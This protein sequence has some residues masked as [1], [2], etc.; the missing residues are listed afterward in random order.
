MKTLKLLLTLV[1]LSDLMTAP[2]RSQQPA[3]IKIDLDHKIAKIDPNI[4]GAFVEPI[5]TVVYGSIYDPKSPFADENGFRKDFVQLAKELNIPVVRW[6]GGNYVSGY[7]WEDGIGPKDQRPTRLDLAWH[8]VESNQ[9]GTDEYA[10][11]CSLI[12]A[13]NF[14]CINAG[15][16]TLDQARH[17]VEYCNY[18]GGTYYSDLRRKY[19]NEKPFKVKYWALGNEIDGPWQMG[20]K[21]AEDYCKF[22]LEAAKIM[23]WVDKD[24]KLIACGA[25]NYGRGTNNAWIDWNDYVLEHMIGKIDYLS[26]HRYVREALGSDTNFPGMMSLGLDIDQKIEIVKALIKKA[27]AK[28]GSLRPVYISFDEWSGGGPGTGNTLTASLMVAQHLNAFIRHADIVK[29][30]NIT[31]LSSLVGNAPEG[32]FKNAL[33]KAFYLYSNNSRGTALDVYADCEKYSNKIFTDIPYLDVTAVLS[34]SGKTMVLNV[35]NRHEK[36]ALTTDVVLQGGAC[37]GSATLQVINAEA[38]DTNSTRTREAVAIT[39]K[40]FQFQGNS[41]SYSFPAH[42]FTQMLIPIQ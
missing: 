27:T 24:I 8:Q 6:P 37:T 35:V 33:Y 2:L 28:S 9:M 5:R 40:E 4:Y 22:A 20:Q 34:D 16:G 25:S 31:M 30:A 3:V 12:G 1:A 15:L 19:G 10:K 23:Q 17:W 42:S 39:T 26:V 36:N 41:I 13:E 29:M 18:Q 32:D 14:I 38:V 7:N 21:S 11:L